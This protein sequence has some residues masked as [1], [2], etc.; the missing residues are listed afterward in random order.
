MPLST[1]SARSIALVALTTALAAGSALAQQPVPAPTKL[2][3]G[4][5]FPAARSATPLDGRIILVISNNDRREPRFENNVYEADT[6]LAFGVDVES[7][8]A[9][10]EAYVDASTF[11][12]P[13]KSIG[14]IP[15]GDY[16]V[17]AVFNKYTTSHRGDGHVERLAHRV[18]IPVDE[19]VV[20]EL[21]EHVL[22]LQRDP[23]WKV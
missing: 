17:Q 1:Q 20:A 2:R 19:H 21:A 5:S 4:I 13:L 22:D 14:D 10:K 6:Q 12:Y 16:W 18:E 15:P 11:G 3:F 9:G 7:L 8:G 23:G